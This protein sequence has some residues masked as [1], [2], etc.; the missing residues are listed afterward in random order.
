MSKELDGL[1]EQVAATTALEASAIVLIKGL[2]DKLVT[3]SEDPAA[4][5]ALAD[6][7][8]ASAEAL[9]AAVTANT[10]APAPTPAPVEEPPVSPTA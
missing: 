6:E 1:K 10:E 7:L 3:A 9:A 4:V 5:K 2:A 8:H